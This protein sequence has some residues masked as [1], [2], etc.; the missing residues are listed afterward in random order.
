MAE[1]VQAKRQGPGALQTL[2][3]SVRPEVRRPPYPGVSAPPW[4]LRLDDLRQFAA[5]Q[6]EAATLWHTST[7]HLDPG[8]AH[9]HQGLAVAGTAARPGIVRRVGAPAGDGLE[10]GRRVA[11]RRA[12]SCSSNQT[13]RHSG[14][15]STRSLSRSPP[16]AGFQRISDS[17]YAPQRT[18]SG[19]TAQSPITRDGTRSRPALGRPGSRPRLNSPREPR[20]QRIE[21]PLLD[22][23]LQRPRAE[24]GVVP[25]PASSPRADRSTVRARCWRRGG[26]R[27]RATG[28]P[29]SAR[30][31]PGPADGTGLCRPP[32]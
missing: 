32:D 1:D 8:A 18:P 28:C 24:L 2:R 10:A 22:G 23:P 6:P 29:R 3:G 31:G 20:S 9:P 4:A 21:Q 30:G 14:H 12:S 17:P 19:A 16:A 5:V 15:W 13:P 11:S 27:P 26:V 7:S 25:F